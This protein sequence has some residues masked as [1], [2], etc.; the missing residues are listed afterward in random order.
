VDAHGRRQ[1]RQRVV[2]HP[3]AERW[4]GDPRRRAE[5]HQESGTGTA[6]AE[7]KA[8]SSHLS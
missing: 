4:H 1:A 7:R 2:S 8:P 6:A 3:K 5:R